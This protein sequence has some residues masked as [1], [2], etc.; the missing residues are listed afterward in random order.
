MSPHDL[1]LRFYQAYDPGL[2]Y[3]KAVTLNYVAQEKDRFRTWVHVPELAAMMDDRF[4][5]SLRAELH[6]IETH[7]F[8]A[9]FAL[10][11][12]IFQPLPHWIYLTTYGTS[13]IRAAIQQYIDGDIAG[14]THGLL[15]DEH[16]LAH[17]AIYAGSVPQ[18]EA[19]R[20]QW[21]QNLD[22]VCW[23]IR[24]MAERYIEAAAYNGG[25]YNT[26]KHGL[27]VMV[28][29]SAISIRLQG[30]EGETP[31]FGAASEDALRFLR[32]EELGE[33]RRTIHEVTKHI[34]PE[35]SL[36]YIGV[37]HHILETTVATRL[38]GLEGHGQ[39]V[40]LNTFLHLDRN[41]VFRLQAQ[42]MTFT[43]RL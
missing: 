3:S 18:D 33:N 31:A 9:L 29:P 36:F 35:E 13:E 21:D 10:L 40:T 24:R 17:H 41:D 37:M 15:T 4:F 39:G 6:F 26:Y 7:Q 16:D 1:N 20:S 30:A 22:N 8:E 2:L 34:N 25:E 23:L 28:G 11:G 12:A 5:G 43:I 14:L 32:W 27:R 38:A 42:A 19:V